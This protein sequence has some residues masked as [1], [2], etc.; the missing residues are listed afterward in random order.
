MSGH[1]VAAGP[2]PAKRCRVYKPTVPFYFILEEA[3]QPMRV[4]GCA[5]AVAALEYISPT[6]SDLEEI[7]CLDFR[8][9]V[10]EWQPLLKVFVRDAKWFVYPIT[11]DMARHKSNP[12]NLPE[13]ESQRLAQEE[14]FE[15]VTP[16]YL[17]GAATKGMKVVR[18]KSFHHELGSLDAART[19]GN[20][21]FPAY[22]QTVMKLGL[23]S[24]PLPST[25]PPLPS[26]SL[27]APLAGPPAGEEHLVD[28]EENNTRYSGPKIMQFLEL[29]SLLKPSATLRK[30][31]GLAANLLGETSVRRAELTDY[32]ERQR[33]PCNRTLE[34]ARQKLDIVSMWWNRTLLTKGVPFFGYLNCDS[35]KQGGFK[36]FVAR[37]DVFWVDATGL[38]GE[39]NIDKALG[40][41]FH[42][43]LLPL[44]CLGEGE[45]DLAHLA[46]ALTHQ[47]KLITGC[48]HNFDTWR[49]SMRGIVTDQ[50]TEGKLANLPNILDPC[51]LLKAVKDD[52]HP[53]PDKPQDF[54]FPA[55]VAVT[56]PLHQL[57]NA[58]ER[59]I[60]DLPDWAVHEAYLRA[61][62][63]VLGS[64]SLR[65]RFVETCLES[66]PL[67]AMF[68]HWQW[69]LVDWKWEYMEDMWL[70]L[71]PIL[72]HFL[73]ALDIDKLKK[74]VTPADAG[75]ASDVVIDRKCL[76]TLASA[77]RD[78]DNFA[79]QCH[80][81][82]AV[83]RSVGREA[84]W[85]TG[86]R[87][88][89]HIWTLQ[90]TWPEKKKCSWSPS[91]TTTM[92]A[93]GGTAEHRS[94]RAAIGK[95]SAR[96]CAKLPRCT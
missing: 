91:T 90:K 44:A 74:S 24:P 80:V 10:V 16:H 52:E 62:L 48:V 9:E 87:C 69:R 51:A 59:H 85:F 68:A 81:F 40:E 38:H 53:P 50:G 78:V 29:R 45:G 14:L 33:L 94:S 71:D 7:S 32:L 17:W 95:T 4:S 88:H 64:R 61:V 11:L 5:L 2:P 20:L 18:L 73:V 49:W 41:G 39:I 30:A 23:P 36:Y 35:S 21:S 58:L 82:A 72:K 83:S 12:F 27:W 43:S 66:A 42:R 54:L 22:R 86:C 65:M 19:G 77:K 47:M 26:T 15:D 84:R 46:L 31:L 6:P 25:S 76:D 92:I 13:V 28:N 70:H 60:K 67:K 63:Q 75:D 1:L 96:E 57:F 8:G 37:S 56:G 34:R 55:M 3:G 93:H 89:D 79:M